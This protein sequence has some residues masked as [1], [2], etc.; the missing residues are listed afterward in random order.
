[1]SMLPGDDQQDALSLTD[2]IRESH[3]ELPETEQPETLAPLVPA[4][5]AWEAPAWTQRWKPE[6]RDALGRFASN[7]E[8]KTY[9]DP[10]KS[11]LEEIN[12]YQ[13]RRD[14]EY[15][16]YRRRLDP[17][18][19]V[20]QPYEQRYA[21]Q[22]IPIQQ[23]V[24]Q[25]FQAAELLNTDPDMA[26]PWL[27]G[28]YRPRNPVE[29]INRLAQSWGID[30]NQALQEQTYIDPTVTA[31]LSPLQQQ[32]QQLTQHIQQQQAGQ[33]HQMQASLLQEISDFESAKDA[34]GQPAHP[35]FADVFDDMIKAVNL[36]YAKNI[37]EA[38]EV[39]SQINPQAR[40]RAQAGAA[41][42]AKKKALDEA[43]ARS[44]RAEKSERASRTV[45]GKSRN[46]SASLNM[47]I[48]EA[49]N[50]AE[51]QLGS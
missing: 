16:D 33:Q 50:Q 26:F 40:E 43:A 36:G 7:P 11:Q 49:F 25:L 46:D 1:M 24:Q 41:E 3:A 45:V 6:A 44:G 28:A 12:S 32:V 48:K 4:E 21:L 34:N 17:V 5:P 39:A 31:L 51:A 38:Y 29:A 27:A 14:Q 20:L 42:A 15:A 30:L 23:G 37:G 8:L 22:G 47:S 19:Q 2:A 10:L 18:Y 13:T 35:L 9:Y